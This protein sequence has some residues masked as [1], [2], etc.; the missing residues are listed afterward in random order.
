MGSVSF[1]EVSHSIIENNY[2]FYGLGC[3]CGSYAY[4]CN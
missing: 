2:L 1:E 4:T 3:M